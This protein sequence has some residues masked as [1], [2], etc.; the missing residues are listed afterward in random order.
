MKK[1]NTVIL[2]LIILVLIG[3]GIGGFFLI[4][5]QMSEKVYK[6]KMAEGRK[7]LSRMKYEEAVAAFEFALEE[8]PEEEEPYIS[9][10]RTRVAQ[11][12]LRL[13][14]RILRLSLIHI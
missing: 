13:A 11:G 10:Y 5:G 1:K 14:Q 3:T 4:Q 12:E 9:I 6:E 8:K 7:Y 2:V